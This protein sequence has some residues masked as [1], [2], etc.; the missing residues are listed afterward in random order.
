MIAAAVALA[1]LAPQ[2]VIYQTGSF[3]NLLTARYDGVFPISR[4]NSFGDFGLGTFNG[5]D[6]E[7]L[8]ADGH[9]YQ[10]TGTGDVQRPNPETRTPFAFVTQFRPD[11]S[12]T[13]KNLSPAALQDEVD[14]RTK[15]YH[16]IVAIRIDGQ[17]RNIDA[18]SFAPQLR[19]YKP[20]AQI[21]ERQ[22][23]FPYPSVEGTFV[24]FRMP[25]TVTVHHLN[26][27]GYHFHFVTRD[28]KQ[29][30]H[31]LAYKI[32]SARVQLMRVG[33]IAPIR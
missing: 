4:L 24:G 25:K 33:A 30:G 12:F 20:F 3:D 26:F 9:V 1:V 10:I 8:V 18:R 13:V 28:R 29:G 17:F 32:V 21:V 31:I 2:A 23:L 11:E 7:M 19:P 5:L 14:R 6:G 16:G 27:P 15:G 22:S